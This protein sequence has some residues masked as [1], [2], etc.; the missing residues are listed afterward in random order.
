MIKPKISTKSTWLLT[1]SR[2]ENLDTDKTVIESDD[3][4]LNK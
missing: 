2:I 1:K 3:I 4:K